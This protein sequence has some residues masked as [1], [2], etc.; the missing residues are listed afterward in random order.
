MTVREC[1]KDVGVS[2]QAVHRWIKVHNIPTKRSG[3]RDLYIE[4]EDWKRFCDEHNIKRGS[5]EK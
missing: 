2:R 5:D 1:V 4:P 3:L